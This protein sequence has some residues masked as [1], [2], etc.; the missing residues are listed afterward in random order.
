VFAEAGSHDVSEF[1]RQHL[2]EAKRRNY[3]S[4]EEMLVMRRGFTYPLA[5]RA[6]VG[7]REAERAYAEGAWYVISKSMPLSWFDRFEESSLGSPVAFDLDGHTLS[8]GGVVNALTASRIVGWCDRLHIGR[9]R[10]LRV[11]EIGAGYG[12]VAH[13]LMQAL[14]ISSYAV[15]DLPENLFLGAFY[16]QGNFPDRRAQFVG[17]SDAASAAAELTFT[18]PPLIDRLEGPFDLILNSYSFQEMNRE[19][20]EKYFEH[21]GRTLAE[22]G[23]LYSLNAHGKAGIERPSQYPAEL[24]GLQSLLPVRRFPWQVFATNPYELVL[25]RRAGAPLDGLAAQD[26]RRGLDALGCAFQL[27]LHD[28]LVP[29]AE[30]FAAGSLSP[31]DRRAIDALGEFAAAGSASAKREGLSAGA[32]PE[33]VADYLLGSLDFALAADQP[34][35]ERLEGALRGL[36]ETHARVR[37]L[38]FLAA[39]ADRRGDGSGRDRHAAAAASLAPHL[40]DEIARLSRDRSGTAGLLAS[41]LSLSDQPRTLPRSR[42]RGL[43]ARLR[44]RQSRST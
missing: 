24:F 40:G 17:P 41:Q 7:D 12:Q 11:L 5:D 15:C 3:P 20:V 9:D 4:F 23:I 19:S 32:V 2:S 37:A 27:G 28:E 38:I 43:M 1:W 44:A 18:T 39:L 25:R 35:A 13:Q 6:N 30:G 31:E 29:L 22:D 36:G 10:P 33:A 34:A 21:A 26:L 8:A 42:L 14:E 16:L